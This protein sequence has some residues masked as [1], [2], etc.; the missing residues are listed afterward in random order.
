M[1]LPPPP[2]PASNCAGL[3]LPAAPHPLLQGP[4]LLDLFFSKEAFQ[5]LKPYFRQVKGQGIVMCSTQQLLGRSFNGVHGRP[6]LRAPNMQGPNRTHSHQSLLTHIPAC[7]LAARLMQAALL[8]VLCLQVPA[9][10]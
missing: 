10:H 5:P 7:R 3:L 2:L 4:Q 8:F 9:H 6:R 1:W